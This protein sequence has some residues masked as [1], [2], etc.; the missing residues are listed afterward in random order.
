MSLEDRSLTILKL[1]TCNLLKPT[2]II[3]RAKFSLNIGRQRRGIV[4][5]Q[6]FIHLKRWIEKIQFQV[7]IMKQHVIVYRSNFILLFITEIHFVLVNVWKY[8]V[9]H[10]A[11]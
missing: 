3:K 4:K 11:K 10:G 7:L 1:G 2:F 9:R 6:P 8:M 5:I